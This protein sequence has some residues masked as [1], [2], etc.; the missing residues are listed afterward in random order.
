MKTLFVSD[1]DGTL[2]QSDETLSAYTSEVINELITK[3][4]MIF[5]YAT[6]RSFHTASKVTKGLQAKMPVIVYNGAFVLDAQTRDVMVSNYFTDSEV[7][8]I[9]TLLK[10]QSVEPIVY[11]FNDGKEQFSYMKKDI[12]IG[13]KKFIDS[14]ND[15][16]NSPLEDKSLLYQGNIF[17][18]TCIDTIEKLYPLYE[19][20]KEQ[21]HCIYQQDIYTKEQWL[22]ILPRQ[23]TKANAILQLKE[24]L[25][26][27]TVV[28][29][30][31][32]ENDV[33]MFTISDSCFA[34]ANAVPSLKKMAT[35]VIGNHNEDAVAKKLLEY[36]K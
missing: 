27:D 1:L 28:S 24:Y 15:D 13:A 36:F 30:G 35:A 31:D 19:Q 22:E 32:G 25:H 26:C 23:A 18:V 21:Y 33:S 34:V 12:T 29:F 20:L 16:R 9:K 5:S 2:L 14:R 3:K 10:E 6:A 8:N 11:A 7:Q 17:Y 4:G